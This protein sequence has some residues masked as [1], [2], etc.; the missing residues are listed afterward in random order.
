[1]QNI[2][3]SPERF[4]DAALTGVSRIHPDLAPAGG[5]TRTLLSRGTR[6]ANR[7]AVIAAAGQGISH[8]SS[9]TSERGL[10]SSLRAP[11][12]RGLKRLGRGV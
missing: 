8:C 11:V 2:L 3:N 5:D 10:R 9:A 6:L 4:V 7:V 12:L 1:M